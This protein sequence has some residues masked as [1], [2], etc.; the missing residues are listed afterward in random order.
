MPAPERPP[1]ARPRPQ[2]SSDAI[3]RLY[4]YWLVST[5]L[6]L[7]VAVILT[8]FARGA[9]RQQTVELHA[10]SGR[11][12]AL[13]DTM[14]STSAQP[15]PRNAQAGLGPA[16]PP[17]AESRPTTRGARPPMPEVP[18]PRSPS[19]PTTAPAATGSP[20]ASILA[21]LDEVAGDKPAAPEDLFDPAGA[22]ALV[23]AALKNVGKTGWSGGTWV[24]LAV[25]A[26]LLGRD[27]IAETFL[28]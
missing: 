28:I 26:R 17:P 1:S 20:E 18:Q 19:S 22:S 15:R 5:V 23:D 25:V 7:L 4:V 12:A 14:N 24:R 2:P 8:V 11:V 27:A 9:M 6:L 13:E 21:T 10:L 3:E 16:T